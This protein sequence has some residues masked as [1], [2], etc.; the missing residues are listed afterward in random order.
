[1]EKEQLIT[2]GKCGDNLTWRF[3]EETLYIEGTGAMY[4]EHWSVDRRD[5][6]D[7]KTNIKRIV[8]QEGCTYI[9]EYVF[10]GCTNLMDVSIPNSVE[11]IG[12]YAFGDCRNIQSVLVPD[13]FIRLTG[14]AGDCN[15]YMHP[16]INRE[17]FIV[18]VL[19]G[20]LFVD[21]ETMVDSFDKVKLKIQLRKKWGYANA[22]GV[23]GVY[24]LDRKSGLIIRD[25]YGKSIFEKQKTSYCGGIYSYW[26]PIGDD[27][28]DLKEISG[29]EAKN[30]LNGHL[31]Q[32]IDPVML[33]E[34]ILLF[35]ENE[36]DFIWERNRLINLVKFV[37]FEDYY[38]IYLNDWNEEKLLPNEMDPWQIRVCISRIYAEHA[39][40]WRIRDRISL[41]EQSV[42]LKMLLRLE[43]LLADASL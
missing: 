6:E 15:C 16:L 30:V 26:I 4:D 31:L 24:Y 18:N 21:E 23:R 12:Y 11:C 36:T 41:T 10:C 35:S 13:A 40:P 1:M 3:E 22:K 8:I 17:R 29:K 39:S 5:W 42:I 14:D 25:F 38:G 19:R 32:N 20:T 28:V 7:V 9:G 27:A 37:G 2:S 43:K 34:L 33:K